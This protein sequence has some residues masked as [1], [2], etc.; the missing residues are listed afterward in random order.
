MNTSAT[1]MRTASS[2]TARATP[3]MGCPTLSTARRSASPS[4]KAAPMPKTPTAA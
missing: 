1:R 3:V 2:T 4:T